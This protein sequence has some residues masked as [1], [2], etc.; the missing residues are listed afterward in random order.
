MFDD[1][2]QSTALHE[3]LRCISLEERVDP[4]VTML[5]DA[6]A[7]HCSDLL[8]SLLGLLTCLRDRTIV[9]RTIGD[10]SLH[11]RPKE[12]DRLHLRTE[13]R[14]VDQRMASIIHQLL[15]DGA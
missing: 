2:G 13:G 5:D 3:V 7:K 4:I 15:N 9:S 12:F 14:S 10:I 8:E 11:L 6:I 1:A